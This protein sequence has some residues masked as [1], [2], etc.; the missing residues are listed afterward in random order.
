MRAS[1]D[2]KSI[3]VES[4]SVIGFSIFGKVVNSKSQG[5][6]GVKIII[7]GQQKALTNENGNY[8]LDDITP[9]MY[10]L[11]GI[12]AHHI[13]EAMNIK[14]VPQSK[15]IQNLI[16]SDYHLCGKITIEDLKTFQN[17][18]RVVIL[19]EKGKVEKKVVTKENGEYC[20]EVKSGSYVVVP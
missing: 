11:E 19:L 20:F 2:G 8:R 17:S 9:G 5:I 13:F 16:A 3:Q 14:I 6:D 12:S 18:K 10:I 15:Q 1:V 4:F 7:D